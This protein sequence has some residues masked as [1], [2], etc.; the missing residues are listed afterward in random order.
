MKITIGQPLAFTRQGM[1]DNQ[2]DRIY[3]VEDKLSADERCF[4]LCDGMGGHENGEVAASIVS[5]SLYKSLSAQPPM[6]DIATRQWFEVSLNHAY[7]A[8]DGMSFHSERKPGTTMTCVYLAANGVMCAHIGDSRIYIVRPYE[9]VQ[10]RSEDHSLVNQLLKSGDL[11]EEEA[12]TFPQRNVI[13]RAMQPALERRYAA[14]VIIND[15][16]KAGDYIFMCCDGILEQLTDAKLC[17]IISKDSTPEEKLNAI[18]EVCKDKTRDNYTCILIPI[19]GVEG[20]PARA[21]MV[22]PEPPAFSPVAQNPQDATRPVSTPVAP[23]PAPAHNVNPV[24]PRAPLTQTFDGRGIEKSNN[25]VGLPPQKRGFSSMAVAIVAVIITLGVCAAIYF[26]FLND[27]KPKTE[28]VTNDS[29]NNDNIP[30]ITDDSGTRKQKNEGQN[31]Q[32]GADAQEFMGQEIDEVRNLAA[33]DEKIKDVFED[34]L[35]DY[36]K[37]NPKQRDLVMKYVSTPQ[38]KLAKINDNEVRK[39][40][41]EK[42]PE[43]LAEI[44][45]TPEKTR[46]CLGLLI[47]S[48]K[49]D[50]FK[51]SL[52]TLQ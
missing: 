22:T 51:N 31:N 43:E 38:M 21:T 44:G 26:F 9:G 13:T 1:K 6:G 34:I 41:G 33:R 19:T 37:L 29:N 39:F 18:L 7:D 11:T 8:L 15:K 52:K 45:I 32:T 16:V 17:E 5:E 28:K 3:P 40:L 4:V 12:A 35:E 10:Y 24:T 23:A 30:D 50:E 49:V 2:E 36:S 25:F 27:P 47:T 20:A 14:D 48:T 42:V 46:K